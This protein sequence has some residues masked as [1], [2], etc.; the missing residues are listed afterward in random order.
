MP[1]LASHQRPDATWGRGCCPTTAMRTVPSQELPAARGALAGD[2]HP[3]PAL[4]LPGWAAA[5]SH[6]DRLGG[7]ALPQSSAGSPGGS[8]G[9]CPSDEGPSS[10]LQLWPCAQ[11]AGKHRCI[12]WERP[13]G[14]WPVIAW[15]PSVPIPMR[16]LLA[17]HLPSS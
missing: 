3:K 2:W 12:A 16:S 7:W 17:L 5:G 11:A 13:P 6:W 4:A 15:G 9:C 1:A 8:G 14:F 10:R